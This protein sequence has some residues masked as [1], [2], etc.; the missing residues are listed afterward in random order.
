MKVVCHIH[1][2][3]LNGSLSKIKGHLRFNFAQYKAYIP[4]QGESICIGASRC[5]KHCI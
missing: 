5:E 4:V 2:Q 3:N 1:L